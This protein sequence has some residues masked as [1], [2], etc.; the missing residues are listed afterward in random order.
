MHTKQG[1]AFLL[2]TLDDGLARGYG[3]FLVHVETGTEFGVFQL[4]GY[5]MHDVAGYELVACQVEG[6]TGGMAGSRKYL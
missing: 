5:A 4:E 3:S 1:P 2:D 6:V